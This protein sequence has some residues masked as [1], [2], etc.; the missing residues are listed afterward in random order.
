MKHIIIGTAGHIDHGKTVLIKALTGTDTDRLKEEKARGI[1]IDLGFAALPLGDDITAGIVD[2]PGHER[3]LKNMLAGT[4]GIDMVM[5]VI[6]A[7]EGVM[8][9]TREHLAMLELLGIKQGVVVLNKIDKVDEEWLDLVEEE[10]RELLAGTFLENAPLCRVSAIS[11]AGLDD[12][13]NH[14][15]AVA[16]KI[17]ARE[18]SAPFRLWIDRVFTVK[19]YGTV[20]TGSALSGSIGVGDT[21]SLYPAGSLLRVRGL[22][23]HN[24]KVERIYAGQRAAINLGGGDTAE[25]ARGMVLSSPVR[26]VTSNTWDVIAQWQQEIS[27]GTRIRLHIGTGE[28]LGRIY[29]FKEQPWEYV[30]LILE[31]PLT[32]GMGDRGIIRQYSPQYL[33]GGATLIAP[34]K[35]SRKLSETRGNMAKALAGHQIQDVI[36]YMIA[37]SGQ[38][39]T[40]DDIKRQAGYLPDEVIERMLASLIAENKVVLIGNYYVTTQLLDDLMRQLSVVVGQYHREQPGRAG[41]SKDILRQ[42]LKLKEKAFDVLLNYWQEKGLVSLRGAEV[43]LQDFAAHHS[44]WRQNLL[45]KASAALNDIGLTSIDCQILAKRLQ[46]SADKA[47]TAQNILLQ[48]GLIVRIGEMYIYS[49][50]IQNIVKL[51]KRHFATKPT[52]TLAELRDMLGTSRKV[53]LP[54]IEFFDGHKYTIREGDTRH[55]GPKLQTIPENKSI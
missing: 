4:G 41:L 15:L 25:M 35:Q 33:L 2:V 9:Q 30:R 28:F 8:P 16:L 26:G 20:V 17:P 48:E 19:G 1:S 53:A 50:T 12:L 29:R 18:S 49:Q 24:S 46:V 3:F 40:D 34:S 22:E 6:A 38:P 43:A 13:R 31:K 23:W 21:L 37:D 54:L 51:I 45:E 39:E 44:D 36:Y 55:P 27:N 52:L 10:V 47:R 7:D 42:K 5:M 32:A 11:G 14:L